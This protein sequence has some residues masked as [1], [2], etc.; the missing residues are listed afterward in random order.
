MSQT[1]HPLKIAPSILTADFGHL[2][3]AITAADQGGADYIHLDVMDGRFVP[4]I[5]FGPL[6]VAAVRNVTQ[7]PL[8]VHLMID[9]PDRYLA[10][11]AQAG[12]SLLTVHAEACVHLHRTVQRITE[13]GCRAGIA[14]NPATP[15]EMVRE[16]VPFVDMVLVMSVNPG[17]GSQ[18]FIET[19]TSKLRRMRKMLDELNPLCDVQVDGGV[20][21]HN[22]DDVVR[23][24]ANVI[25]V[26]SA[27]FNTRN[28]PGANIAA[29]RKA[30]SSAQWQE[31]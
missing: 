27:V 31:V 17:F 6:V 2:A 19:S 1:T 30:A 23:S 18:R 29:L 25:V 8:D 20:D 10:D 28:T 24:G 4:N 3:T 22:I 12:A 26:G 13:L 9:D 14:I 15:V 11:F 16:I 7:L 5:T 21:V